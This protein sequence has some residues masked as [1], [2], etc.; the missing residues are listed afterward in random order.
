MRWTAEKIIRRWN[1]FPIV[2]SFYKWHFHKGEKARLVRSATK[3]VQRMQKLL[4][5]AAF[6]S[7][8]HYYM[9][10]QE[11]HASSLA[12]CVKLGASSSRPSSVPKL[13]L[14]LPAS[15]EAEDSSALRARAVGIASALVEE[16]TQLNKEFQAEISLDSRQEG[17]SF[18]Y[19]DWVPRLCGI[20]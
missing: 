10:G 12:N 6:S 20:R 17:F 18:E 19:E 15:R 4:L 13:S 7:L 9:S 16:I 5:W 11:T 2:K 14:P 3:V 1:K 8:A